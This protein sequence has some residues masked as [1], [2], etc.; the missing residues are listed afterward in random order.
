MRQFVIATLLSLV[1]PSMAWSGSCDPYLQG[2]KRWEDMGDDPRSE[3]IVERL[4]LNPLVN[5]DPNSQYDG[6]M[7]TKSAGTRFNAPVLEIS[8]HSVN[9]QKR[10]AESFQLL[11]GNLKQFDFD[12]G[13]FFDFEEP[14]TYEVRLKHQGKVICTQAYTYKLG[15]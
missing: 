7:L 8:F 14:G 1:F 9:R 10:K 6:I 2:F 12:P 13:K 3:E 15:H 11:E 4:T 5:W